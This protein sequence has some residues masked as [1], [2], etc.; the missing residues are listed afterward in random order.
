M[1]KCTPYHTNSSE[2]FPKQRNA[3]RDN[4]ECPDGR[5]IE[6]QYRRAGTA[7]RPRCDECIA[8]G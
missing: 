6:T 8:L 2:Y 5:H 1:A 4:P 7:G 3:Y